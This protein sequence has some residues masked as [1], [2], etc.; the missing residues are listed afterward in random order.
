M[1]DPNGEPGDGAKETWSLRSRARI[2]QERPDLPAEAGHRG[3][4]AGGAAEPGAR[5]VAQGEVFELRAPRPREKGP[6]VVPLLT[7]FLVGRVSLRK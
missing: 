1:R 4:G 5:H 3:P 7:S 2:P 6:P